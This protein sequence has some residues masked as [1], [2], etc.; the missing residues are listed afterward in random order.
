MECLLSEVSLYISHIPDPRLSL[1]PYL[2]A[3][4]W[5]RD[6]YL[7]F[8][9]HSHPVSGEIVIYLFHHLNLSIVVPCSQCPQLERE[10][11]REGGTGK[12]KGSE[13]IGGFVTL[14]H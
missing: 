13:I 10:G 8:L 1:V 3:I 12:E 9:L 11:W 4:G 7:S 6:M 2:W 14:V 5:R